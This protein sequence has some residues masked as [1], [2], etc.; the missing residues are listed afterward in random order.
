VAPQAL[1]LLN[2]PLVIEQSRAFAARLAEAVPSPPDRVR[3]AYRLLFGR[4]PTADEQALGEGPAA[5]GGT[6]WEAYCQVLLCL[7]ELIYVD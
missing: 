2:H 5:G 3:Q 1:F 4:E 7:N 6:D